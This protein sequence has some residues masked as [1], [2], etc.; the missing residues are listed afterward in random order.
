MSN[1]EEIRRDIERT[2]AE[3]SDNVNALEDR[4]N[5]GNIARSQVDKVKGGVNDIK[6]R[7]FGSPY[8]PTDSGAVGDMGDQVSG[9]VHDARDAVADAP[10]QVKR[11]TRGNPIAAGLIAAG[12]GAL[13]GGLIPSSRAEQEAA[14]KVKEAAEP[15]TDEVKGMAQEAR[16]HLQPMAQEAADEVRLTAE[17]AAGTVKQDAQAAKDNVAEQARE[18]GE[19]VKQDGADAARETKDDVQ[20]SRDNL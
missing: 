19:H 14:Q 4:S 1:P 2:R 17:D 7:V 8:D 15:L 11:R 16:D 3:L 18:S 20:R 12:V 9:A 13:I 10:Q 6:E 5:P